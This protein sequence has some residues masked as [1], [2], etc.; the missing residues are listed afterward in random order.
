MVCIDLFQSGGI[1]RY[2]RA[3]LPVPFRDIGCLGRF[4]L[5]FFCFPGGAFL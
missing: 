3:F 4:C 1:C 2:L 5:L